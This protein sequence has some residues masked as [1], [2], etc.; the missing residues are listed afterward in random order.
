MDE[1]SASISE[2]D[3][4]RNVK[5]LIEKFERM[6]LR[7]V[8]ISRAPTDWNLKGLTGR[9]AETIAKFEHNIF[10]YR[11]GTIAIQGTD[12]S[13]ERWVA[14]LKEKMLR[15][16]RQQIEA[17]YDDKLND[18]ELQQI[19]NYVKSMEVLPQQEQH[20]MKPT[21]ASS[22]GRIV[23]SSKDLKHV[24]SF[25]GF[26]LHSKDLSIVRSSNSCSCTFHLANIFGTSLKDA[27]GHHHRVEQHLVMLMLLLMQ[28]DFSLEA[29]STIN[30][31][32]ASQ[33]KKKN[34]RKD[35]T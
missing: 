28:V 15:H 27:T 16:V 10:P 12:E 26:S 3:K 18:Q 5:M 13:T 14:V 4:S 33:N 20:Q 24:P 25:N 35:A 34:G 9:V 2:M 1:A 22:N 17:D 8:H 23:L 11:I 19:D 31:L 7:K 32:R 29:A 30:C 6:S 21:G